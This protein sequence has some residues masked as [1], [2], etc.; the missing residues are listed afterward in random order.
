TESLSH[1]VLDD[2]RTDNTFGMEEHVEVN[3][4]GYLRVDSRVKEDLGF[5]DFFGIT[6]IR[7]QDGYPVLENVETVGEF[8]SLFRADY[9][10][11]KPEGMDINTFLEGYLTY[12]EYEH[13]GYHPVRDFLSGLADVTIIIPVIDAILG[14]DIITGETLNDFERGMKAAGAVID[15]FTLGQ[16]M[17]LAGGVEAGAGIIVKTLAVEMVSNAAGYSAGYAA[18]E[19]GMPLPVTWILSV[20]TGCTVSATVGGYLFTSADG[21]ITKCTA[22][23]AGDL[24][25]RLDKT[26]SP[27][28]FADMMSPEDA[29]RYLRFLENGSTE[30]LT[31][32]ELEGIKKVDELLALKKISYQDVLDIMNS[33][34]AL[35]GGTYSG[36]LM[37]DEEAARCSEH[38][39]ELGIGS[40]KTWKEFMNANPNGTIDNYFE[41]VQKQS[42]WPLGETG[43]PTTLKA[44]D[45]FFMAVENDAPENIIGGFGVKERIESTD[46]VRN[47]LAVKY[48]WKTSCNIIREFEVNSGIELNVNA[49]PVG[50]QIDLEAD[51]YLP[52]DTA[53]T[54]Y[55]LFSN[56]ESGIKREDYVHIVDEY[57]V[58]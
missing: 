7:P 27:A 18:N 52:G 54:Q 19:M 41:I 53:I 23:E 29:A 38:W 36:D 26:D 34:K 12:G 24:I 20:A 11:M 44:G 37:S 50:P 14:K 30:G 25:K 31:S 33:G 22:E 49:G 39:R 48:D 15:L 3:D 8:A 45:R 43:T 28:S 55:D 35:E 1:I 58:D 46:F 9:D 56:L 2:I 32:A 57:W 6:D 13:T 17:V 21:T 40:D 16:A 10:R 4:A 47:N 51:I 5:S 42:P